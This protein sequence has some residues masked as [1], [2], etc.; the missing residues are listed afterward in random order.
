M[1]QEFGNNWPSISQM[2]FRAQGVVCLG[3]IALLSASVVAQDRSQPRFESYPVKERFTSKPAP[4]NVHSHPKARLFRTQLRD[5]IVREGVNFAGHY[6]I[7][8][9]GCGSDCRIVAIVD[10]RTGDVYFAPFTVSTGAD[11]RVTSR[12]F[13]ANPSEIERYLLGEPMLDVYEPGWYVW[14][15]NRLVRIHKAEA[16]NIRKKNT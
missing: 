5:G 13:I 6:S 15:R 4:V 12:L 9:W 1:N 7:I 16:Q 14:T 2:A 3:A 8:T 11:F 10:G